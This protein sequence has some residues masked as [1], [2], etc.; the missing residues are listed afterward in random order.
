MSKV[1]V[2]THFQTI[3]Q[4]ILD[5]I[6]SFYYNKNYTSKHYI[7]IRG[8]F[9][10]ESTFAFKIGWENYDE[11]KKSI[12][13]DAHSKNFWDI[14]KK[15]INELEKRLPD[16]NIIVTKHFI[17]NKKVKNYLGEDEDE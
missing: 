7:F 10:K 4:D 15:V 11:S 2:E 14:T 8:R 13:I 5:N 3:I 17:S 1:T 6:S 9:L 12:F 16:F